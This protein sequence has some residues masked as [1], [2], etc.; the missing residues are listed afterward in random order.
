[1]AGLKRRGCGLNLIPRWLFGDVS[2]AGGGDERCP[3]LEAETDRLGVR[4]ELLF[5]PRLQEEAASDFE[6][7]A[8]VALWTLFG[9]ELP[10]EV[11]PLITVVVGMEF[12][13]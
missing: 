1:M 3:G 2:T 10:K 11:P 6:G 4:T 13:A 8:T 12:G 9:E 7:V 5:P